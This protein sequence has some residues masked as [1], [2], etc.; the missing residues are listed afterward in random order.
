KLAWL[1][2]QEPGWRFDVVGTSATR[3]S[4]PENF[5]LHGFLPRERYAPLLAGADVAFATLAL[6]RKGMQETSSLKLAE[7]LA[8]GLPVVIGHDTPDFPGEAP[9]FLLTLPNTEGNVRE[10][11]EAIRAFVARVRGRRVA[12]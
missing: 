4:T 10:G 8:N 1:A 5:V 7:Y 9:W 12:H 2:G 6:H 11:V 3:Y